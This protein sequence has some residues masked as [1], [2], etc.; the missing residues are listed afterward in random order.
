[1]GSSVFKG[2][3]VISV[4]TPDWFRWFES[5]RAQ[6]ITRR[7]G[8]H[9]CSRAD[10]STGSQGSTGAQGAQ[11]VQPVHQGQPVQRDQLVACQVAR[12]DR[13]ACLGQLV[14]S[15]DL[16]LKVARPDGFNGPTGQSGTTRQSEPSV[17]V[18]RSVQ[19]VPLDHLVLL[20]RVE[21][22]S[23]IEGNEPAYGLAT[24]NV[25]SAMSYDGTYIVAIWIW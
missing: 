11:A 16:V 5:N 3:K 25:A 20:V 17:P 10:R 8:T 22:F 14:R 23:V 1:M 6:W 24:T 18:E 4:R 12:L 19:Q 15:A 2:R 21:P 7:H 9:R 13:R